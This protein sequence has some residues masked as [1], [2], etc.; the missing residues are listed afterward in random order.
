MWV[1]IVLIGFWVGGG[2]GCLGKSW[3]WSCIVGLELEMFVVNRFCLF[4]IV[5]NYVFM[6]L[7]SIKELKWGVVVKSYVYVNIFVFIIFV[8]KMWVGF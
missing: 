5:Y 7:V 8:V 3:G 4:F 1:I 6:S 2:L